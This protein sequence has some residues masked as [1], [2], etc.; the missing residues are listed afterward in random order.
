MIYCNLGRTQ[1]AKRCTES[2]VFKTDGGYYI[3]EELNRMMA[4]GKTDAR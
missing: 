4:G 2:M 3:R 1:F